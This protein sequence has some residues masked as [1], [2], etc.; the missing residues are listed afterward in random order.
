M[1]FFQTQALAVLGP[2]SGHAELPHLL[3]T[4]TE[5]RAEPQTQ[6]L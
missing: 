1:L 3:S 2:T 6:L 4:T 5:G